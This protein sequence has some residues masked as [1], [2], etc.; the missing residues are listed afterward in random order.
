[1]AQSYDIII[2]GIGAGAARWSVTWL[3][4]ARAFWL[5]ERGGWMT[6]GPEN[7]AVFHAGRADVSGPRQAGRRP[8]PT[9]GQ[10][11]VSLS[12]RSARR[13]EDGRRRNRRALAVACS[14]A[15]R[16]A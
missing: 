15:A 12:T 3:R 16:R 9:A 14:A 7:L 2:I 11:A 10:R 5:L 1:M 13:R 6:R 8:D 4:R